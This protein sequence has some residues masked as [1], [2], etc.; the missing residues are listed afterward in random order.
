[1]HSTFHL[2]SKVKYLTTLDLN[3]AYYQIPLVE[4]S[5]HYTAFYRDCNLYQYR[6]MLSD[7]PTSA[8]VIRRLF[9]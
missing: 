8:Q 2:F 4:S 7:I 6:C 9:D 3:Q 1:M 5:K